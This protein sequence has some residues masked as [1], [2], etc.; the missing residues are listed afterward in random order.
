MVVFTC[1]IL[2]RTIETPVLAEDGIIYDREG[3]E[4]W[5]DHCLSINREIT[6]PLTRRPISTRLVIPVEFFNRLNEWRLSN[7]MAKILAPT[8]FGLIDSNQSPIAVIPRHEPLEDSSFMNYYILVNPRSPLVEFNGVRYQLVFSIIMLSN[9]KML[10]FPQSL[11]LAENIRRA[12]KM[13]LDS[14]IL[15]NRIPFSDNIDQPE[16]ARFLN[17]II[18]GCIQFRGNLPYHKQFI[19]NDYIIFTIN[20]TDARHV[21]CLKK[22]KMTIEQYSKIWIRSTGRYSLENILNPLTYDEIKDICIKNKCYLPSYRSR[23][24]LIRGLEYTPI[25]IEEGEIISSVSSLNWN[26]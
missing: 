5:F 21:Q 18:D 9:V 14:I 4:G 16:T 26:R 22:M 13:V 11:S 7:G 20:F 25:T 6:S 17:N 24:A 3:I 19:H 2:N 12:P 23:S 10:Y 15:N 8:N 1:P